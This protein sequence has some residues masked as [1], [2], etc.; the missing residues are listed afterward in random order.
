MS[1]TRLVNNKRNVITGIYYTNSLISTTDDFKDL[2][3]C[4][5]NFISTF[6]LPAKLATRIRSSNSFVSG[7]NPTNISKF[8]AIELNKMMNHWT[9]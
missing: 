9:K 5:D 6:A 2:D 1:N 4:F 8:N 3:L 7:F